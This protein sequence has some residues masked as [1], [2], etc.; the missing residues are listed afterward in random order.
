MRVL[1]TGA[2]GLVGSHLVA[3]LV[4]SG[5]TVVALSRHPDRHAWPEGVEAVAWDGIGP[6]PDVEADAVVNLAGASVVGA[7]WSRAN[8]QEM[9]DSRIGV[10]R[11]V[12]DWANAQ[13]PPARLVQASAAGYYGAADGPCHEDR[14]AGSGFLAELARDWETAARKTKGPLA[15]LRFGHVLAGGG[16]YLGTLLPYVRWHLAGRVGGG[17]QP[18]PWVHIHDA[19]QAILWSLGKAQDGTYNVVSPGAAG[20]TQGE[21]ARKLAAAAGKRLQIPVPLLAIRVRYG[22]GA[23]HA[24]AKGADLRSDKLQAAGFRFKFPDLDEA[25]DQLLK[26]RMPRK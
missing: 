15:V 12:V 13:Q 26:K 19:V 21:F 17:R 22:A 24:L 16:G 14:E 7:R 5:N 23:G 4:A 3:A 11:H 6:L 1:V 9:L 2:S 20:M 10:T 25:L 8:M 18:M